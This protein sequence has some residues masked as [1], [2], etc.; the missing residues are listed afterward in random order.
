M[1]N[2]IIFDADAQRS[3]KEGVRKLCN[4][5]SITMGPRGKLVL[6]ENSNPETN[7]LGHDMNMN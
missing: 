3:L 2:S 5:V 7:S 6:I 1:T 4:A